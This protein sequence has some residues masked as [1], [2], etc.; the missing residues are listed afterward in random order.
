MNIQNM[1]ITDI[2]PYEKNPRLNEGAVDAVA[3]SIK[4]FGWRAP[5]VVDK[6]MVIICGHTRLKAAIKLGLDVVPV[7]IADN[8]TPEQVQAY[9]IADNK[10]GEIA[11]WDYSLL[12]LELKELQDASFDLS[13]LGFDT[14]ELDKLLN[15]SED[16]VT[17]GETEPDAVPEAPEIPTSRYGEVYQLGDHLLMCGDATKADDIAVLMGDEKADL[18]LTDPPYNVAYE[19]SNGLTIEN[20][21]MS[22]SKFRE[23]LRAAFD[24]VH[25][26]LHPGAAFYIFHAD[27]EGYNFRGACHDIGLKVRQCLVWKKNALVL[28][29][30]DYQWIHEPCLYGWK[31][32]AAHNWFTDRSQTTVMEFNKPKHND[33]HPTMKPVEMLIY[34]LKNS[35]ERGNTV[36]DTFGG[37]GSTLIACEQ[38]GRKCR[39]ME[40]DPKYTDVIRRRWA[41]F[42]HGEGC[43]WQSLT[44]AIAENKNTT[45]LLSEP[46]SG[47]QD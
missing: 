36:I 14:D 5:I 6:D 22:D 25:E 12:P 31:D 15:R 3:K 17:D 39:T 34:L 23:F 35:S 26:F 7:H 46:Q 32:G 29:R 10:T 45:E 33:V 40:L 38:T 27:S 1:K 42:T 21:N 44:P 37:S 18:W 47:D 4:E 16:V 43:D 30:Q 2:H 11:E 13:L 24:N 9:R 8:L 20:D 28:G 19:G 41:E